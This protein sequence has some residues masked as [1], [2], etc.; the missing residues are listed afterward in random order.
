[1]LLGFPGLVI[2]RFLYPWL[3][4]DPVA[5]FAPVSLIG[6]R[7]DSMF[8]TTGSLLQT[9]RAG[10]VRGLAVT[11]AERA[12][13]APEFPTIAESGVPGFDVSGWYGLLAP[14]KTPL[15]IL[16]KMHA[17]AATVLSEP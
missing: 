14:A 16:R 4:Y 17:D 9:A 11:L 12:D 7:I 1:M 8:N 15:D 10:T 13:T 3:T 5:D 2:N 6:G